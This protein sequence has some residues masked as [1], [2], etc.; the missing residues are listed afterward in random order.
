M[1]VKFDEIQNIIKTN[2]NKDTVA[3]GR[4]RAKVLQLHVE[5]EGMD[6]AIEKCD[7]FASDEVYAVQ[8]QY[9]VSNV[10]LFARLLQQEDMVFMARG[11]SSNFKLPDAM[12][13]EM[14]AILG[15]I[16]YGMSLRKWIKTFALSAYRCD[17]M[18]I[19][20]M[21]IDSAAV[22]A[23][24]NFTMPRAYPTYKSTF[25]IFDYLATGRRLEYVCFRLSKGE[26][27]SFGINDQS[28]KEVANGDQE[29]IFY[30]FVDDE[31]DVILKFSSE[32]VSLVTDITQKNPI[33]N[34][35]NKTPGFIVSDLINYKDPS[36]FESP[37]QNVVELADTFLND[38]S[39]RDLQKK[40]HG[41]CK[42]I[43]PLLVCGTCA[44]N[45]SV[46]GEDCPA[47]QPP[48]GGEPTGYKLKTKIS[49]V[50]RFPIDMFDKGFDY[51]KIFGYVTP[52]I[53]GWEKQ[54][55]SL[56]DLEQLMEMT[57]WGTIRVKRPKP[58]GNN[59][60][61]EVTATEV[62]SN[63]APKEARL[64]MTADWAESTENLVADFMGAY[65]FPEKFKEGS[66]SYGRDYILRT[67]QELM[68]A[69]QKLLAKGSPDFSKDEAL[70]KVYQA[71]YQNNPMQMAKYLKML[72]V[73]PFP[74]DLVTN[75]EKSSVIPFE[76]KLAKRYFGEFSDTVPDVDW[77]VKKASVLIEEL[78]A[79]VKLKGITE[80]K[81]EPAKGGGIPVPA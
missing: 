50:A 46:N 7:H 11:G 51:N 63:D 52:D 27:I 74:H 40:F 80:P 57:Y 60:G 77:V 47:C 73:E 62:D 36:C 72:N 53:K 9:A 71:K 37:L 48:G 31:K 2:P 55:S 39:I 1:I 58:G 41:F 24:G 38:R 76:D 65:F 79:Y 16:E 21:E 43:E 35:W 61:P 42:A 5:G 28:L 67:W 69:Y 70:E 30:R 26:A 68:D 54:D 32:E 22:D 29:S 49:D 33:V 19:I 81:P 17:P 18:G 78:K 44:G 6:D 10:D 12:E 8:K 75:I 3:A 45:K 20:F 23:A 13:N 25:A 15:N 56:E 59:S 66:I 14:N 34:V 64:N 4:E